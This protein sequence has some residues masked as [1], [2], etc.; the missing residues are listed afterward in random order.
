M[1]YGMVIDLK[2]CIGCY[3]CVIACKAENATPPG[4]FYIRV[5]KHETGKYPNVRRVSMPI[6]CMHCADPPCEK[7]CPTGASFKRES[8]GVVL[9]DKDLCVGCRYC[10]MACPYGVRYFHAEDREYFPGQGLTPF[11]R[12]GYGNHPPGGVEKCEFCFRRVGRELQPACAANCPTRAMT[13]GDLEDP[14]SEVS[15]LISERAGFQLHPELGTDPAVYY[16]S[17]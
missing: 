14:T 1:R 9:I 12:R 13:F 15:R 5:F 6:M 10:M 17:A 7:A 11:E 4:V 8:D 2:R 16:L 3:G